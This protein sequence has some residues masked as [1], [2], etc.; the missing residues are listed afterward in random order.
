MSVP[1][2]SRHDAAPDLEDH[3]LFSKVA[4]SIVATYSYVP[5]N[6]ASSTL[7]THPSKQ[8]TYHRPLAWLFQHLKNAA[9]VLPKVL[10]MLWTHQLSEMTEGSGAIVWC[11]AE[12]LQRL[13]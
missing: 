2:A 9:S 7:A 13:S 1:H 4:S 5:S 6:Q 11:L 3:E 12:S 8:A 10:Q